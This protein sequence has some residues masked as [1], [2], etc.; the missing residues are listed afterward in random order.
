M[1]QNALLQKPIAADARPR[2]IRHRPPH[3]GWPTALWIA[4]VCTLLFPLLVAFGTWRYVHATAAV[5][6]TTRTDAIVV[7]GAAQY[8]GTPSPVLRSR[9]QHAVDLYNAGVAPR[10]VTVGGKQNGDRFTEANAGLQWL[11]ANGVDA[12]NVTAVPA[13]ADTLESLKEV[14]RV[15]NLN[16]W[17]SI[18]I[19][20]DPSH[21]ARSL[22]I[23]NRLGFEGHTNPTTSGDGSAVT[24]DYVNRETL[25]LIG[26]EV[27]QQWDVQRVI[28]KP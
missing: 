13:G 6:D 25:A 2:V 3:P 4:I 7:L 11:V 18:T 8:D 9:L 1:T 27:L 20:S 17:H 12:H 22:A 14:A 5:H 28:E 26:F 24:D 23:A 16:G 21:M 15:A 19:D 10:I